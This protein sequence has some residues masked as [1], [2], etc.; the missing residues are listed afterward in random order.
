MPRRYFA[1]YDY[2]EIVMGEPREFVCETVIEAPDLDTAK[3]RATRYFEELSFVNGV[4]W[5]RV[6]NHYRIAEA[7]EEQA[8]GVT[9]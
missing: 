6:L 1:T 5:R 2:T 3:V 4:G 8:A 7:P 9:R